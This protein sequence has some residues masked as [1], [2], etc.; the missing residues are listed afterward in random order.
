M[1]GLLSVLLAAR[2][3][4]LT[5]AKHSTGRAA[6]SLRI[7]PRNTIKMSDMEDDFMCDDEED[8]D[9]EYSEDSNSEPNVDLENQYYNSKALKEDDPKAA[10]SSFQKV[11]E[12]EGEKGEWGF[13]ALKQM[14]KI[15]F[16]LVCYDTNRMHMH[17]YRQD[18]IIA[19]WFYP[20]WTLQT[21]FPEMMNRYKQLLTYIRSAVTRNY[22][23]KSINSIL[24]YIST[25]KQMD[26]LQEF[27]ET[28]LEA[29]KDAKNDR[30]WF[31][32]NTKLGKLY[33]ER[34]EYGKLQKI[35][36]QLHQSCQT[37]D[38]E[39]DLKKGTQLL[40]IYALEIQ[41]YTAQKNNKKLKA[42][43][44]QSL[45][46]KS[47]IPHPLIMGVI[48]ECGGKM[49]LREG[50]FEKAHTDFFEAFKNYDESGS[51]RRTTC[52]KYLV[53]AN[54][55]MKSGIN[56]FDSQE[57]KPY[58]ND[59]EILAMTNLVSA[60]QNNDITEFEK[61]L[62]TNHSNIM[63]DPFIREHIEELLRNIRTQVLI[64]LIKPYTRIHI[65]FISKELNIDVCD[66]ESLLVQCIL[67]NT[68]HGRI[69]Q[70]NQLLELDYQKRGGARY[71]A[72]DKW[73]NQLNSLNQAIVSK[74][75]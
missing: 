22:S 66:V 33:L 19:H 37:D 56:P 74:L 59:P 25:S 40:E 20:V 1:G 3:H 32:T 14:I 46:I 48:R 31:K 51:P 45:H 67:D 49:H 21:N 8:Y 60:Y 26:L 71:T 62:K 53:L 47:A 54:M 27:Y 64:K 15:N 57:A 36:R 35:L 73:T 38:G 55:L 4:R 11:L 44:E 10:L 18:M 41:M 30:L 24:D 43:Y 17:P 61:I 72:L 28:T 29:L 5:A 42:L 50:E 23:E 52:L 75:T 2:S 69:D 7:T 9:L 68:I 63:D 16:K 12:L 39:D 58:K 65:P 13:K 34:E 6:V 70:V